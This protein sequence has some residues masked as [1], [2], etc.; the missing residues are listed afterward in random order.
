M[1]ISK[2]CNAGMD[3]LASRG[4]GVVLTIRLRS[5]SLGE[6][7]RA[8]SILQFRIWMASSKRSGHVFGKFAQ[9]IVCHPSS[10]TSGAQSL[11]NTYSRILLVP[12]T[13]LL[14]QGEYTATTRCLLPHFS[15]HRWTS[16]FLKC[17]LPSNIKTSAGANPLYM[18]CSDLTVVFP[19]PAVLN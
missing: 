18:S 9:F 16:L 12:S 3:E 7:L 8:G 17:F 11:A 6:N 10:P 4:V 19:V 1:C 14:I 13:R 15:H 5:S 2:S